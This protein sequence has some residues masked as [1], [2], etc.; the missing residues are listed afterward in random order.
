MHSIQ[1]FV[2]HEH[3]NLGYFFSEH[4]RFNMENRSHALVLEGDQVTQANFKDHLRRSDV[5]VLSCRAFGNAG[6]FV[7]YRICVDNWK[8]HSTLNEPMMWHHQLAN[9]RTDNEI[10]QARRKG[11]GLKACRIQLG[12]RYYPHLRRLWDT[13]NRTRN[14]VYFMMKGF[15]SGYWADSFLAYMLAIEALLSSDGRRSMSRTV[16]ERASQ[17]LKDRPHCT[18]DEIRRLYDVR[19]EIV[20]GKIPTDGLGSFDCNIIA[21]AHAEL[22]L[23]EVMKKLID[24]NIYPKYGNGHQ[25]QN[26]LGHLRQ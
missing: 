9:N 16:C 6:F 24:D 14:A 12:D 2:L 13:S 10:I 1:P 23:V 15:R 8:Y 22:I 7:K 3:D 21:V 25:I 26:Y 17:L 11:N 5:L 19:S 20:H 18:F 4:D